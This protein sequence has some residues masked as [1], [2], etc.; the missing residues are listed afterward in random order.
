MIV[1]DLF[2]NIPEENIIARAIFEDRCKPQNLNGWIIKYYAQLVKLKSSKVRKSDMM[3]Y[4]SVA[5]DDED[6][7]YANVSGFSYVDI[8]AGNECYYAIEY[9]NY[10]QYASLYVPD[11]M[12]QRYGEEV[13]ASEALREYGWSGFDKNIIC[14]DEVKLGVLQALDG[15]KQELFLTDCNYYDR[16]RKQFCNTYEGKEVT[17]W[18]DAKCAEGVPNNNS[19]TAHCIL[20]QEDLF[21]E[22]DLYMRQIFD[23]IHDMTSNLS[24]LK[25]AYYDF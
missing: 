16:C 13:I 24:Y 22:L 20:F 4:L 6:R 8:K 5:C 10:S 7:I 12:V 15:M 19:D 1:R 3:F 2:Q 11:Y 21:A 23:Y 14:P 17:Q 25:Y 18:E 9:L